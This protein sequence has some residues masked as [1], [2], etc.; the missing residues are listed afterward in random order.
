MRK[1]VFNHSSVETHWQKIWEE[2]NLYKLSDMNKVVN[3][4]YNL[5]MFPYPS[6][7]GLHAGHAFAST[8]SDVYGRFKRM[9]A[10]IVFQPIGY[11]SFGIHS[12]N[13]ALKIGKHPREM[14][15]KT[16]KKYEQ[17]LRSL[18]HSYDWRR[19]VT[20]S[21]SDY[22]RWT[23][24]LFIELF[25]AGLAYRKKTEVNWCPSDKTVLADE[26]V[27]S[28]AQA[29][30]EAKDARGNIIK[31]KKDILVC[32][33]CGTQVEKKLLEQWFFRITKYADRLLAG[34]KKI[35]WPDKVKLAQTNWI[36]KK[37]GINIT[38]P[39]KDSNQEI[40][41]WTSRPDTNFGATFIVVSPEYA[42]QNLKNLLIKDVQSKVEKY[43][44]LSLSK[45]KEE[46]LNEGRKK[47]GVFTGLY[48]LNQLNNTQMP[49]WVSDFVLSEVGTGAVVGVPGHDKRDFE[50]AKGFKLPI[51]RVVVGQDKDQS[52]ITDVNQVQEEEGTMIN[53]EFLNGLDIN[54]AIGKMMDFLEEKGWGKRVINYHLRDWLVSRQRYWGGPIP[55]VKC[56]LCGWQ[57]VP[58]EEL[59][60]ELPEISDYKPEGKG[61]G[62]LANHPE[63]FKTT[64]PNCG[65]SAE[66][67]T[68]VMDT[69]VD[70]SWYFLRYP[71]VD[72]KSSTKL[73]FDREITKKW[74][75]V[76]L[77]FGGAEHSVL[78]LMYARFVTMVLHDR[79]YLDFDEPF[80]RFFA[81]GLMIKD[82]GKMSKSRGNVVNPDLYIEKFGAD[83]LRLYLMFMGPMDG[84][85]DFRDTGIEGMRRF[86]DRVWELFTNFKNVVV[87]DEEGARFIMIK[88]HQTIK[89]VTE[90]IEE[91]R[92]NTAISSIMEY[93]NLLR[94]VAS[95]NQKSKIKNQ[96]DKSRF[97][98]K[99]FNN[100]RCAEWDEALK[101][102][103]LLLAPFAPHLA[104]EVWV[105]ILGQEFSVHTYPWPKYNPE[106]IEEDSVEIVIQVNGKLRGTISL[107]KSEAQDKEKV[108]ESAK[109]VNNLAKWLEGKEIKKEIFVPEKLGN[110]LL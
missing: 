74:L 71:S 67:E 42:K 70:S 29:G 65:G 52:D 1:Q 94:G 32:E 28:P 103:A 34:L 98:N 50:F 55:M 97:K 14:L 22:Y 81:R 82:G 44:K 9:N 41:V 6:A 51:V 100:I 110:F 53:S 18:G 68:D 66:R 49:I 91:F 31:G 108:I 96:K 60:V 38:Y 89:K 87:L 39:I 58:S 10:K 101:N 20:T 56:K 2:K 40:V 57:P 46:R 72:S 33:R 13:Y 12:E 95:K 59:P 62:P 4:F 43:I 25:K 79:G 90:D 48:A 30:K 83:T 16:T 54:I 80:P 37:E 93:I 11:D 47:T 105:N 73:P 7:E 35:D 102:L 69:F 86:V 61:R 17:Q 45:S 24:W 26:Q 63:F 78:H 36:G 3:A 84:F 76:S 8:G 64:C 107:S 88:M 5:W 109:K 85:P 106:F 99:H 19:T 23:Q 15:E 27:M 21:D 92:Y 75:P 77:Y 104:E